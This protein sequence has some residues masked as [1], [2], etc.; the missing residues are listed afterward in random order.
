MLIRYNQKTI[1]I[2]DRV[3]FEIKYDMFDVTCHI[4]DTKGDVLMTGTLKDKI[5]MER[6]VRAI[7]ST[8]CWRPENIL[9]VNNAWKVTEYNPYA[10]MD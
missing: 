5:G 8:L 1:E 3:S 4:I 7:N 10:D 6:A 9:T 2:K